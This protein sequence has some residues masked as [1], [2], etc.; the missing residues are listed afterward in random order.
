MQYTQE[1]LDNA[2]SYY[3]SVFNGRTRYE[4]QEPRH[5]EVIVAA[6]TAA[7]QR[8]AAFVQAWRILREQW[9]DMHEFES[10]EGM[11]FEPDVLRIDELAR[12]AQQDQ[13]AGEWITINEDGS[14]LPEYVAYGK[15]YIR[16][17]HHDGD[18][19]DQWADAWTT[20]AIHQHQEKVIA[21]WSIPHIDRRPDIPAYTA[22]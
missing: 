8:L 15:W 20:E 16:W 21:Y 18:I 9:P 10:A 22:R 1:Q 3:R 4:G 6:L 5:D 7:E 11:P 2:L 17:Q 14:N 19:Q 12:V 13:P